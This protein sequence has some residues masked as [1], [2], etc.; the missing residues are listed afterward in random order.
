MLEVK[1]LS[2]I[3]RNKKGNWVRALN[4]VSIK[5]D[6]TGLTFIYGPSGNGKSTLLNILGGIE[7]W[8]EGQVMLNGV[9]ITTLS[10][11]EL[12][13]YRNSRISFVFQ[14][15]NLITSLSVKENVRLGRSFTGN[16]P[17][18]EEIS[19]V[20]KKLK[21]GG[22]EDRIPNELSG[23]ERQRVAIARTLIQ[24]PQILFVDEPTGNLDEENSTQIWQILKEISK[25]TLIVGVSHQKEI[26]LKYADRIIE[27]DSGK[28]VS[29]KAAQGGK[30]VAKNIKNNEADKPTD[31]SQLNLKA[32]RMPFDQVFSMA[33]VN[34][35]LKKVK[36]AFVILLSAMSLVFFSMFIILAG[37]SN[38]VAQSRN[39]FDS[40]ATYVGFKRTDDQQMNS[41][42]RHEFVTEISGVKNFF[43][44]NFPVSFGPNF[45]TSPNKEFYISG[46]IEMA[47]V[48]GENSAGK[49]NGLGQKILYGNY[50]DANNVSNIAISDYLANMLK[51]YGFR[52]SPGGPVEYIDSIEELVLIK[53]QSGIITYSKPVVINGRAMLIQGIYETDFEKFVNKSTMTLKSSNADLK[54]EFEYRLNKVYGVLHGFSEFV[55][56]YPQGEVATTAHSFSFIRGSAI[57][58]GNHYPTGLN[59]VIP[60][61]STGTIMY[62]Y[63]TGDTPASGL[64]D[65]IG[66]ETDAFKNIILPLDLFNLLFE[67]SLTISG[68][69]YLFNENNMDVI[70]NIGGTNDVS[71]KVVGVTDAQ[72]VIVNKAYFMHKQVAQ[73]GNRYYGIYQKINFPSFELIIPVNGMNVEA[74]AEIIELFT[75]KNYV[76]QSFNARA[77][78]DFSDKISVFNSAMLMASIFTALF[79]L[80]LIYLFVSETIENRKRDIGILRALGAGNRDIAHIFLMSSAILATL[81]FIAT[82]ALTA[83]AV[84]VANIVMQAS[85]AL[86]FTLFNLDTLIFLWIFLISFGISFVAT[87]VPILLFSRKSP[88]EV[89]KRF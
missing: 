89:I 23:G 59:F 50:P 19:E 29:D 85:L 41:N 77:I 7:T 8:D 28:V 72:E 70:L 71:F 15:H 17:T 44:V 80:I 4:D 37:Y 64:A 63:A 62:L 58:T 25:T 13:A 47:P 79:S 31:K 39:V 86:S 66:N 30:W 24:S 35:G 6:K 60:E 84:I 14:D 48:A 9:D 38:T 74:L 57:R 69:D 26:V 12:D 34:M 42:D 88:V 16:V 20:L 81:I 10:N 76:L 65:A 75:D 22:F 21:L 40:G 87:A 32:G 61:G 83:L 46:L 18:D 27:L 51:V 52:S 11:N 2:K 73:N 3:Y 1:G 49:K 5:F 53:D 36:T 68:T 67:E 82:L 55:D 78:E 54:K 33:R 56:Y 45:S 43:S